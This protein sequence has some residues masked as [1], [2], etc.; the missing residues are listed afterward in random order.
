MLSFNCCVRKSGILF[1]KRDPDAK[2]DL[3]AELCVCS[4]DM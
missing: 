4:I 3:Q 1:Q 2:I